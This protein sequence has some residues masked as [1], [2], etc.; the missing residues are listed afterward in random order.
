MQRRRVFPQ[1][2][3]NLCVSVGQEAEVAERPPGVRLRER[4][5]WS[6][7]LIGW[8]PTHASGEALLEIRDRDRP[9][10]VQTRDVAVEEGD[11]F[12]A[13]YGFHRWFP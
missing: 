2:D 11:E 4:P 9:S 10:P 13:S 5:Q 12:F 7:R 3:S 1:V 8:D 6:E